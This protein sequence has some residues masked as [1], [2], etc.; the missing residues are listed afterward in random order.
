M[1]VTVLGLCVRLSVCLSVTMFSTKRTKVPQKALPT[2]SA[3]HWLDYKNGNFRTSTGFNCSSMKTK[4][5]SQYA[6]EYGLP[7]PDSARFEHGG[8]I[9][10][11]MKGEYVVHTG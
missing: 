10:S 11:Y 8:G 7:R 3:L 2:N 1:R 5:T 9:I 6:N 4:Q